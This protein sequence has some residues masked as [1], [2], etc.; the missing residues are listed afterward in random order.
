MVDVVE[1]LVHWHAGRRIGEVCSSLGVDPKTVRKYK[2]PAIAAGLAPGGP[3]LS[4]EQWAALVAEWFPSLEDR[5]R[6]QKTWPEIEPH[7][8][9]IRGWLGEVTVAT[10]H[11]RLRDDHGLGASES[12]LR[13]F[14]WAN[15][16]DEVAR[17][18]VRVLRDTPPVGEEAQV[19]YG[20]LGRWFDPAAHRMRRVWS[21]IMVLT[22]SRLMF[23][24]P[25]LRMDELSWV[26]AH[27][28]LRV[29]RGRAPPGRPRQPEAGRHPPR[30]L[31]PPDQQGLRGVR[32][33]LRLPRRPR[34]RAEA[35]GQGHRGTPRALCPGLV[36]RRSGGGVR[37][38]GRHAGRRPT[39]V[40]PGR[41]PAP[42][43]PARSYRPPG[44]LRR[45]RARRPA[46]ASPRPFRAGPLVDAQGQ[47]RH[48]IKV[49][50]AL[51]SVPWVHIGRT[52]DAREGARTVE[53][54]CDGKLIK[55]HPR[56]ERGKQTDPADYPPEKVAFFMRTPAWC[57]R[58][59]SE[60]GESVSAVVLALMEVNA[61]YR[62]RQAQGVVGL[63][64]KHG[65]ERLDAAC[66]RALAVGDPSYK[67]V[68]GILAAGTENDG[69]TAPETADGAG[70]PAWPPAPLRRG[71]GRVNAS[72]LEDTL[73]GLKLFGM[74][75]TL[76]TR[77]A[78]ATAGELGHVELVAALCADEVARR[79]AA[80]L[81]RWLRA[82]RF[83]QAATIEQFD[84]SFNPKIPAAQIRDLATLRFV[85]ASESVILHGPVGV[86]KS[87][88]A[89]ALGH[90][91]CRRGHSV[92]FTKTS[93]LL[94]DL[95]GG[96]ADRSWEA[97]LRRWARPTILILDD[98]AIRDFTLTQA[99]DLYE[100]VTAAGGAAGDLYRQRQATDWYTLFPNPVVAESILDRIVNSAHHVHMDGRS[101]RPNRRPGAKGSR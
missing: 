47:P 81:E 2:A 52:V 42:V 15:F 41:Q 99:D 33:P 98:F 28:R 35:S 51:Y 70:P 9:R 44:R 43:P 10:I 53:V 79:D 73:R 78:K 23:L 55:T 101:Y 62:L 21:F 12:S 19:D 25:V 22:A 94:G 20:L 36:L 87:M 77:L 90:A 75:D 39:V 68:Q 45:H 32:R 6:R 72:H 64:D 83:E 4:A 48:P 17:A 97:R 100:L 65:P 63:A 11:Q 67:T 89:Q 54:F 69:E 26:E 93:R 95:A 86:G 31:R 30:P 40:P 7:R 16:D 5:T 74:L 82:A 76:T 13:R 50:K 58:R 92:A 1:I 59:A 56:I 57:R 24:R 88:I 60:L 80:G 29:L 3:P 46:P 37:K 8:E 66:R 34:P 27:G 96:H 84:F 49:G 91:A 14:I 18:A 61:L 38:P 85:D 71:G